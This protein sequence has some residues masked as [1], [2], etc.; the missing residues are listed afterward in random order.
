MATLQVTT[1]SLKAGTGVDGFIAAD[2]ALQ[3]W[4]YLN[5]PGIARRTT[6]RADDGTWITIRLYADA[7]QTGT[8]W[9]DSP[10]VA[11][12]AWRAM[13]DETSI[14]SRDYDLL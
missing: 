12:T 7:S 10:D 5:V 2:A 9:F 4:T 1:Y 3:E 8:D 13:V 14:E 11:V 6:A